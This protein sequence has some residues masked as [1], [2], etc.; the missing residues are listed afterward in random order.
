MTSSAQSVLSRLTVEDVKAARRE[1]ARRSLNDYACM[2]DIPTAPIGE[3]DSDAF[4]TMRIGSLV[5]H[6]MLLLTALADVERCKI[7]NLM[8]LMPPGSAKSIYCDV[9]FVPWFMA[10]KP[11]RNVIL[12]SY[13]SDI[14][15][16]QGRRARQ[17]IKSQAWQNLMQVGLSADN[18]AA[19]RWSLDN[20]S[21]Y[22]AG[23]LLSGLT[24]NRGS[25]G[26]VDDPVQGREQ[27]ESETIRRKTWDSYVDDFCTR[28][29]PGAP[30][31]LI[32][33]RWHQADIA[34]RILPIDWDGQS[35]DIDGRDGRKWHVICLPAEA[36]RLDDPL[37]RKIGQSLW[38][39][40][41][42]KDHWQPF[43]K[44]QRTWSSLFQQKPSPE[45]GDY[46][47]AEWIKEYEKTP[48]NLLY[49]GASDY[50]VTDGRGDFTEHGIFGVDCDGNIYVVDWWRGQ[51]AS[52]VW[53]E[54]KLDLCAKWKPMAWFGEG[55]VIRH[56]V[57][58]YLIRRMRERSVF[59]RMEW[60]A[61]IHDKPTRARSIQARVSQG[62][63]HFKHGDV[64]Q[65]EV[66]TQML[67]FPAG[68]NDDSVDVLS[69][70]GRGLEFVHNAGKP[71]VKAPKP[72]ADWLKIEE[73][74]DDSWRVD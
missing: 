49:Y 34:G 6:H 68:V 31:V 61:S 62:M 44:N 21:E 5:A 14:A 58:P 29:V 66:R 26:I 65:N 72:E 47:R 55:G 57:E 7:K 11:R 15:S 18:A 67:S 71:E 9:V 3:D 69:I 27:A 42:T 16:K 24:G 45:D 36:D 12:A 53:I 70:L 74:S 2:I 8:V 30:Q 52:D 60:L 25:L 73:E 39:E 59:V 35:G 23:G 33:T 43:K 1:L 4:S 10:V 19:D 38:P 56:A 41:F 28:L 40:W 17:L 48:T 22:M 32:Q 46:F 51:T 54:T 20:G 50:A 64:V 63:V 37:G 13:A